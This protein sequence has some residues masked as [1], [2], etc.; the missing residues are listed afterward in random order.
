MTSWQLFQ[1]LNIFEYHRIERHPV[2][3]REHDRTIDWTRLTER[4]VRRFAPIV[5]LLATAYLLITWLDSQLQSQ[6]DLLLLIGAGLFL[7]TPSLAPWSLALGMM[8]GPA[9]AAERQRGTWVLLCMIPGGIEPILLAKL[10]AM[11]W[12]LRYPLHLMRHIWLIMSFPIALGI[13]RAVAA[14]FELTNPETA[15]AAEMIC[16]SGGLVLLGGIVVLAGAMAIFV[17]DRAHQLIL[18][19]MGALTVS[20]NARSLQMASVGAVTAALLLW[21]AET[22]G[23][24]A[25]VLLLPGQRPYTDMNTLALLLLGP[26]GAYAIDLDIVPALVATAITFTAREIAIRALWRWTLHAARG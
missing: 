19:M 14:K 2:Y 6:A 26:V 23:A 9:V 16:A 3:D 17:A 10:R 13:T 12:P 11:L 1:Y 21:L 8:I 15:S 24:A 4:T 7:L 20:A 5:P 18:M 25:L 22:A